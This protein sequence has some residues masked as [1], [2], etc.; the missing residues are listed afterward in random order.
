[1]QNFI[2]D[3]ALDVIED[4]IAFGQRI[5]PCGWRRGARLIQPNGG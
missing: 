4:P 1:M 5:G 2:I 3:L